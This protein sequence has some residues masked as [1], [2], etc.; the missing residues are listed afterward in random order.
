MA[1][2]D[3][4]LLKSV[5]KRLKAER[6]DT[7]L[8]RG[9]TRIERIVSQQHVSPPGF[10]FDQPNG[11]WVMVLAGSAALLFEGEIE[12]VI[13]TQ[14]DYIDIPAH[15]RHRIEW[16]DPLRPTVWLAVHYD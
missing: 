16:T 13:L 11:E 8:H 12:P 15:R 9:G 4:N 5:P 10:W 14:G 3:G 2:A 6:F 1:E 7:L